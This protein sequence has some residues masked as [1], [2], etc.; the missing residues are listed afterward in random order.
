MKQLYQLILI[1]LSLWLLLT[2]C[3]DDSRSIEVGSVQ[4]ISPY[5]PYFVRQDGDQIVLQISCTC[6]KWK[7]IS[8]NDWLQLS[9]TTG[10]DQDY[11]YVEIEPNELKTRRYGAIRFYDNNDTDQLSDYIE[12][13]QYGLSDEKP[14]NSLRTDSMSRKHRMGYGYDI[15]GEYMSDN[16]F[17]DQPILNYGMMLLLEEKGT[18]MVTEDL[19]HTEELE[20]QS[21]NTLTEL[22]SKLTRTNDTNGFLGCKK[23]VTTTEI[24]R[25]KTIDQECGMIRLKEIVS[26]RTIDRGALLAQ[27]RTVGARI[28][29]DSFNEALST[30]QTAI[31][32]GH[33]NNINNAAKNLYDAFGSHLV[34]SADLGGE[35]RVNTVVDRVTSVEKTHSVQTIT[36]KIFGIKVSS[37]T[38]SYTSINSN[39]QLRYS[40]ELEVTGG[41]EEQKKLL[42][43]KEQN[44]NINNPISNE[45]II[46]WQNSFQIGTLD[47][48]GT[49]SAD[50]YNAA[51]VN[52][53][54]VPLY[55]IV[56]D[57]EVASAMKAY[58]G[59]INAQNA[60]DQDDTQTPV[61]FKVP[62]SDPQKP[63]Q[64]QS[65]YYNNTLYA[66]IG[67]E[68]VPSIRG[69][70]PCTV[71]YPIVSG[72]PFMYAG[73]FVG[74]EDHLP[75]WVRWLGNNCIYEP[76]EQFASDT[77]GYKKLL[78]ANGRLSQL[79]CYWGAVQMVPGVDMHPQVPSEIKTTRAILSSEYIASPDPELVKVGP[80]YWTPS[81]VKIRNSSGTDMQYIT[82]DSGNY[83]SIGGDADHWTDQISQLKALLPNATQARSVIGVLNGRTSVMVE[84]YYPSGQNLLGLQWPSGYLVKDGNEQIHCDPTSW[85]IPTYEGITRLSMSGNAQTFQLADYLQSIGYLDPQYIK[86]IPFVFCTNDVQ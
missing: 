41:S 56:D 8:H 39:D 33:Q 34:L 55:E 10:V 24:F 47:A 69:D 21:A 74:D 80:Y 82:Y 63:G 71:A 36:K 29:S 53:R 20:I 27:N 7:A 45:E 48:N 60:Q 77:I 23:T 18:Q 67:D 1:S 44:H 57:P 72:R 15:M 86:Y 2:A 17:S 83:T 52:C 78:D 46:A 43:N 30:L 9:Q 76:D 84:P 54:L 35:I 26:S 32:E 40:I 14:D 64:C 65:I 3:H 68:Y 75:G 61:S 25:N 22:R 16:S 4:V 5:S 58:L 37:S 73:V 28:F 66:V 42:R 85:V 59:K 38:S 12:I 11:L 19:R 31:K 51:M 13:I 6:K 62:K 81:T 79:H 50:D 49:V 70:K